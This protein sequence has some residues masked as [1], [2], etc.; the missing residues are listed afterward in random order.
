MLNK[1]VRFIAP[2]QIKGYSLGIHISVIFLSLFGLMMVLSANGGLNTTSM[3][4]LFVFIKESVFIVVSYL[5]MVHVSRQFNFKTIKK[6]IVP[7]MIGMVLFNFVPLFFGDVGGAKAWIRLPGMT[8][9]P[10]EFTKVVMVLAFACF[11]GD[12]DER[13]NVKGYELAGVPLAFVGVNAFIIIFL[14]KDLG[15]AAVLIFMALCI[16][17]IPQNKNLNRLQFWV[18][19]FFIL[20]F[21]GVIVLSTP[22]GVT[23]LEKVGLKDY[24]VGRFKTVADPFYDITGR[25]YHVYNGFIAFTSGG[26]FGK[27]LGSSLGKHGFIPEARTDFILAII[28]EELGMFGLLA[29]LIPYGIILYSLIKNALKM[30]YDKDRMIL[31][32]AATYLMVHFLFNVGGITALIPLTGVPL[33]LISSGASSKFAFLIIIGIAQATIAKAP[34]VVD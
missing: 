3:D 12:R 23:I 32:G 24:M 18:L 19:I 30:K 17:M 8:I 4:L 11:L 7:L 5:L 29:V 34:R 31:M 22:A 26:W 14:Q 2:K 1:I 10:S 25:G 28:V 15:S 9:Q 16:L 13:Q 21:I 27:G 20:G 6:F 33:L